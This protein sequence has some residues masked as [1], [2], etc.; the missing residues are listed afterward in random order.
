MSKLPTRILVTGSAGYIGSHAALRLVEDGCEV[1]GLDDFTRGNR[2]AVDAINRVAEGAEGS[3]TFVEGSIGDRDRVESLLREHRIELVMHFAAL[4]Y[5]GE[6][7][8]E[9]L[10]YYDIN[11]GGAISLLRAVE[12]AGVNRFVFSSTC[13]SY[14]EPPADRIPIREDCPQDPI[15]PYGRSKL[16]IE[17][18]LRDFAATCHANDRPFAYAALRYFNVAGSDSKARI[19]EDHRPETHLVPICL[20]VAAGKR[21]KLVIHGDD[22][23]TPDGTCIRDYVHVVDLID[24]HVHVMRALSDGEVRKYNIGIGKGTSVLEILEACREVT[25]HPIPAEIGPRREGDPPELY[26]DASRIANEIGWSADRPDVR[27]AVE[28]AWRWMQNNPDG[29]PRD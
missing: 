6:S 26:A 27:T 22:Y 15:N 20:E 2:G 23:P 12:A 4:A 3:Y 28:D 13:A 14:G 29:Y 8:H 24:A 9:P 19:G 7:V 18:A 10:R 5:V 16:F 17:H 11:T 25:G 21:D 1:V